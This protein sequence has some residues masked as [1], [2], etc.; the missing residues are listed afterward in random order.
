M[1]ALL[2]FLEHGEVFVELG[3]VLEGGAV[4]ALE[5]RVLFVAF[6]VG[7]GDVR[8]FERADVAGAHDVRAGAEIGEFAVAI[9]RD[10][11]ALGNV[12]DD[13]EFELARRRPLTKGTKDT[14]LG[15]GEGLVARQNYALEDMVRFGFLFH[16]GLDLL[17]IFGRDAVVEFEVV[18]ETVLDR[19]TRGE[20]R[21]GP[22][23]EDGRRQHVGSRVPQ[24][25][26]VGHLRALL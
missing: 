2:R 20:L 8:E 5:L 10:F 9:E 26:D 1:V 23:L 3:L 4:D 15:H 11:F 17:E 18:I 13:I 19:R 14:T 12:L 7:A 16:L 22:D 21:V 24:A 6:V 25:L